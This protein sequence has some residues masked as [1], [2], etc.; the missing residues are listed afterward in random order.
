MIAYAR[1]S[2]DT[3]QIGCVRSQDIGRFGLG[4]G[5]TRVPGGEL[6][7]QTTRASTRDALAPEFRCEYPRRIDPE[8]PIEE[9]SA[10]DLA[11]QYGVSRKTIYK[12]LAWYQEQGLSDSLSR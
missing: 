12:W 3:T 7:L 1:R 9:E 11:K 4:M 10:V 2:S 5:N 8:G 6:D